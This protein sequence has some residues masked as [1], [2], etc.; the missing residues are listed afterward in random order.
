MGSG[1]STV[2]PLLAARL[3]WRFLDLDTLVEEHT[4]RSIA[5]LFAEGE[6]VFRAAEAETLTATRVLYEV[7]VATGGGTL[8]QPGAMAQARVAGLVIYLEASA[9]ALAGWLQGDASRPLLHG[10]DGRPLY[11]AA[12]HARIDRLLRA[13]RPVYEQADLIVDANRAPDEVV[14]AIVNELRA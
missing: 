5:A 12:L 10:Q 9:Q 7:V 13:R 14:A 8:I 3:D 4:G 6:S 11:G 2:G 1:K